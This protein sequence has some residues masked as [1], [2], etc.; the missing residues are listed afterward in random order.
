MARRSDGTGVGKDAKEGTIKVSNLK[1]REGKKNGV[2]R[3]EMDAEGWTL[4]E[5]E[6]G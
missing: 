3:S 2:G 4:K 6:L 5:K 1:C